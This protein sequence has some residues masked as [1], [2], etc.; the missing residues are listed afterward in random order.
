MK[1]EEA[2]FRA[3]PLAFLGCFI[4]LLVVT[5]CK[6]IGLGFVPSATAGSIAGVGVFLPL[7]YH[8]VWKKAQNSS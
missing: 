4:A 3:I 8:F 1:F 2:V 6:E 5:I 7:F